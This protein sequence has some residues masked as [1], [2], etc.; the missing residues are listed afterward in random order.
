MF[1]PIVNEEAAFRIL[2]QPP[3]IGEGLDQPPALTCPVD[4]GLDPGIGE[5]A[6]VALRAEFRGEVPGQLESLRS[7]SAAGISRIPAAVS[8]SYISTKRAGRIGWG[9]A[10]MR[11]PFPVRPR[12]ANSEATPGAQILS[13]TSCRETFARAVLD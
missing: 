8:S 9:A 6:D 7:T 11:A 2:V 4:S 10:V 12:W 13:R 1:V 5:P 3:G